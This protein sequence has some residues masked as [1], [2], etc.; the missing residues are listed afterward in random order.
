MKK[1]L[2]TWCG[3]TDLKASLKLENTS[4]PI[5]NAIA[6][7]QYTDIAILFYTNHNKAELKQEDFLKDLKEAQNK[8]LCNDSVYV[9]NFVSLYS[10][11]EL[12]YNYFKEW[13]M[14]NTKNKDFKFSFYPIGLS[15]L[16]DTDGIYDIAIKVMHDIEAYEDS[17]E[18]DLFLSPGT[19]VMAFVWALVSLKYP[20]IKKRL[21]SSSVIGKKPESISLPKDWSWWY[22]RS[23]KD[24]SDTFDI[25]FNL[26]GEQ[27]IPNL[28][29]IIQF[30]SK[31]HVFI[32]SQKY[33]AN[34]MKKFLHNSS[35]DEI[36]IDP[37]DPLDVRNKI[38]QYIQGK[39]HN[40]KIGFN[41]TSGTKLMYAGAFAACQE[42]NGT[43]FYF[44]AKDNSVIYL[45]GFRKHDTK[46]IDSIDTFLLLNGDE[47]SVKNQ[48]YQKLE[49]EI[50][51]R[52]ALT[53]IFYKNR[54]KVAKNYKK[55]LQCIDNKQPIELKMGDIELENRHNVIKAEN[56]TFIFN[57]SDIFN[58]YIT[59]GW[60]E[61]YIYLSIRP[62]LKEKIILDLKI[63]VEICMSPDNKFISNDFTSLKNLQ[64]SNYQEFDIV[65]TDGK[66]LYIIEC[67]SGSV[68]SDYIE[69]LKNI[70]NY[71]GGIES[72]G[73]LAGC[74]DINSRVVKKKIADSRKINFFS[75]DYRR[76]IKEL[77][78]N[79]QN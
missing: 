61:E 38:V 5:L 19:P 70:T 64:E 20:N 3:I 14:C 1:I 13:I 47:L 60:F 2:V 28:L 41:L 58:K 18:V 71:F 21:L 7:E 16:N 48:N 43:A 50:L 24:N 9:N 35:F 73:I 44:N 62:L 40:G 32:S 65:F 75:Y 11:T 68:S 63:N 34:I 45:D 78:L 59:G 23:K 10:D 36:T 12:A 49:N 42:V 37:Y 74:F 29:S 69:K 67:K 66:R 51:K 52:E 76:Q 25:V 39:K 77:I 33:S 46:K 15:G 22:D 53:K 57:D 4:G 55:L 72:V 6:S 31:K 17:K 8:F 26:F 79:H 30:D 56:M 27:R 54:N